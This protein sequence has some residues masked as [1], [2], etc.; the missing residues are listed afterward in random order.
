MSS[1]TTLLWHSWRDAAQ[2]P[3][4]PLPSRTRIASANVLPIPLWVL[5]KLL[6]LQQRMRV[7]EH[8]EDM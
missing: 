4:A 3:H 1:P 5:G 2:L 7:K 6:Q 8:T